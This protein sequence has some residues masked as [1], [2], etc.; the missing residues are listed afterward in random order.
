MTIGALSTP[1]SG[2]LGLI[3]CT[4]PHRSSTF[5]VALSFYCLLSAAGIAADVQVNAQDHNL[6]DQGNF[7]SESE[8]HVAVAGQLVVVGYNSTKQ[9]REKGAADWDSING[10][11]FSTDGGTTF[12]E[13]GLL[14]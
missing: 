10:Y 14:P 8:T 2:A 9:G 1:G 13:G 5:L 4:V 7:T 11:A 12:T 6:S 3:A